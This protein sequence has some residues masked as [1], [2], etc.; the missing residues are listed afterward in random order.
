MWLCL[1]KTLFIKIGHCQ[2]CPQDIAFKSLMNINNK[3]TE[4]KV[5]NNDEKKKKKMR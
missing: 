5:R 2:I 3:I 1:N 4:N